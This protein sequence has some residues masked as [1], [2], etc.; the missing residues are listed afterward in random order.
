MTHENLFEKLYL[1]AKYL[2]KYAFAMDRDYVANKTL[3]DAGRNKQL[4]YVNALATHTN[5]HI[6]MKITWLGMFHYSNAY[7]TI[8]K[9]SHGNRLY[10]NM[11]TNY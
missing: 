3:I 10:M 2:T 7:Y 5:A 4:K 6:N 11:I 1:N 8:P 9:F